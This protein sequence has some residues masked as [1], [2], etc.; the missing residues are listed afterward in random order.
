MYK[1]RTQCAEVCFR[2]NN[3][4]SIDWSVQHSEVSESQSNTKC[5]GHTWDLFKCFIRDHLYW[6]NVLAFL[7]TYHLVFQKGH[8]VHKHAAQNSVLCV[9]SNTPFVCFS[10]LLS[11]FIKR[12][13]EGKK[14]P[15]HT[16]A[17][18]LTHSAPFL[19]L[20]TNFGLWFWSVTAI[21]T[22]A[23][24][25][26]QHSAVSIKASLLSSFQNYKTVLCRLCP[27]PSPETLQ[28]QSTWMNTS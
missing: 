24:K 19:L 25:K 16:L 22:L 6:Q 26:P 15:T 8:L 11:P 10:S 23:N 12:K 18:S 7:F 28:Q 1:S 4:R 5:W 9:V 14:N 13:E 3:C 2:F 17:D 27:P 21:Y 20:H